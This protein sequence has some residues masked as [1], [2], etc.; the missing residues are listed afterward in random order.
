VLHTLTFVVLVLMLFLISVHTFY[1]MILF[2]SS[3]IDFD[4]SNRALVF[5]VVLFPLVGWLDL[6]DLSVLDSSDRLERC[7]ASFSY[8]LTY[9]SNVSMYCAYDR[10]LPFSFRIFLFASSN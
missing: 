3:F 9:S 6:R 7:S 10:S 5:L 8:S 2:V 1:F 4:S